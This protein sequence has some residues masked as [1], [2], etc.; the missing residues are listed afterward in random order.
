MPRVPA[1]PNRFADEA[2]DKEFR[3][4]HKELNG[5]ALTDGPED[6]KLR[7]EWL[8]LFKKFNGQVK[9]RVEPKGSKPDSSSCKTLPR[10]TLEVY[11][12][13]PK[14]KPDDWHGHV[15]MVLQQPNGS[16]IRYSMQAVNPN[17]QG[18]DQIQYLVW[19]QQTIVKKKPF[20]RGASPKWFGGG[21]AKVIRIPTVNA[22]QVQ[23]A[24]DEYIKDKSQYHAITNNCA[25]FVNDCLNEAD[26]ISLWDHTL[27]IDY[28]REL[29]RDFP[30][31][32]VK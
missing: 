24:V 21:G 6:A 5:R 16:Y 26:D 12:Y 19:W 3:Q 29:E 8:E 9:P 15:G 22:K 18:A 25:D 31:C 17:L 10:G 30:D 28:F 14:M 13:V 4:A 7:T 23:A 20:P 2:A 11:V 1:P 27:P 32:V